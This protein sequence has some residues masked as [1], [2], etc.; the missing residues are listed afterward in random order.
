[1]VTKLGAFLER[2]SYQALS[3][4]R[5]ANVDAAKDSG[6]TKS[7]L[8]RTKEGKTNTNFRST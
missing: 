7:Q 1:M 6:T 8:G 5:E 3:S 2:A 4:S